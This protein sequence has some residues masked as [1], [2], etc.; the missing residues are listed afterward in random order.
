MPQEPFKKCLDGSRPKYGLWTC[1]ACGDDRC[2]ATRQACHACRAAKAKSPAKAN[3]QEKLAAATKAEAKAS[4][5]EVDATEAAELSIEDQI[6]DLEFCVKGL[7]EAK[8]GTRPK[9]QVDAWEASSNCSGSSRGEQ[10]R[11]QHGF[12][13]RRTA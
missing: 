1:T 9:A 8:D 4:D 11:C 2:F 5:M 7:K 6:S 12:M 13:Q 3:P 10:R